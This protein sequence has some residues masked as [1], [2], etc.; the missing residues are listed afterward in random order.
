AWTELKL[1]NIDCMMG[2]QPSVYV[3][4]LQTLDDV[5]GFAQSTG[6]VYEFNLNQLTEEKRAELGW[7]QGGAYNNPI[8]LDPEVK[9]AMAM[10]IDKDAFVSD[11]LEGLGTYADSL[12]PDINPWYHRYET[13]VPFD[14]AAARQML[15]DDGWNMDAAGNPATPTTTPLYGYFEDVLQPLEFRFV[16]LNDPPEWLAGAN[17]MVDWCAEAGVKLNLELVAPNQMNTI[18][19]Y[20]DYDTWLWDWIFTPFSEP[21][22]DILSV[23]TTA[24]IGSWSDVFMSEPV[25]DAMYNESVRAMDPVARGAILDEMQDFAY[26]HFSCQCVAYRKELYAVSTLN[27]GN[28]GDW[29]EDFILMPDQGFPYLYML[30]SPNGPNAEDPSNQA[31]VITSLDAQFEGYV[32]TAID[33]SGSATDGTTLQY[34]WYWGDGTTSGWQ[35]S[36]SA[37]HTYAEDGYYTVYFAARESDD[38]T[39]ADYFITWGQTEA[40]VIDASNTAPHSLSISYDPLMF[41]TGD[42]VT[43][44]GSAVDDEDDELDYSWSFGDMYSAKGPVVEHQYLTAGS[45]TVTMSVTDNRV[46]TDPRPVTTNAL[47]IA[48]GNSPPTIDVP[49][50]PDVDTDVEYNF[51]VTASDPESDPIAYTWE[52]GDGTISVTDVDY[53]LH[54]YDVQDVYDLTVYADDQTGVDGHNVSDTGTVTVLSAINAEPVVVS[55]VASETAVYTDQDVSFTSVAT[56]A[57]GDPLRFTFAFGDGTFAVEENVATAPDEE[58][59]FTVTHTYDTA[60]TV[61]AYVYVWDM[62]DNTS[63]SP[64]SI[65]VEANAAPLVPDLSYPTV[66]ANTTVVFTTDPFDPDGDEMS[67]W[68]DFGDSSS[69]E[70]G[71]TVTHMYVMPDDYVYRVYVDDGH[72]HNETKAGV[73]TVLSED[74]NFAPEITPLVN[75]TALVGETVVF[76]ATATDVN[77][78]VLVYT[79]DFGD[80]SGLAVGRE[81]EHVYSVADEYTFTVYVDDGEFNESAEAVVNVS[82]SAPPVA[83]AGADQAVD[84]GAEVSFDGSGSTDDLSVV[85]YTWTFSYD[86]G[87]ETL[88][89]EAPEFTF[90]VAG[91]YNVTLTVKDFEGQTDADYVTITVDDDKSFIQEYGLWIALVAAIVVVAV[92]V[93]VLKGR[94][95]GKVPSTAVEGI[96][97]T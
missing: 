22:T 26:E 79:W 9:E 76:N 52:W 43:F 14:T 71:A 93:M 25:F 83:D 50:F 74:T 13:P 15:M 91:E 10:C 24:E 62:Q 86:G 36:P 64:V 2:V 97:E 87:T 88:Y 61:T 39:T 65:T 46:G 73:I 32:D 82:A 69:M 5:I 67:I 77:D 6:F 85:N 59:S 11:V 96:E 12:I 66:M 30:I 42:V 57:D 58:V 75:M 20:G 35:S 8:L 47:V 95:G 34:Q 23:L 3:G 53:A 84:I 27:W 68:W 21:S 63:S 41:D 48:G 78:D 38:A 28:Y 40:K 89:G 7:T 4:E 55:F 92:V 54:T 16:T 56:D 31:P 45:Y 60:G 72:E 94:K 29:E 49:D 81:V 19:Y 33:F 90:E 37:T 80:G 51:T 17:L 18:W 70:S 44:T 1:G